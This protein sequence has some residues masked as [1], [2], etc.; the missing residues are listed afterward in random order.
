MSTTFSPADT[1]HLTNLTKVFFPEHGYTK[2]DLLDYYRAAAPFI[3]PYLADRPMVL[4]RHVDGH[5]KKEFFQRVSRRCPAWV[6]IARIE[7]DGGRKLRDFHLCQDWPTLLWLA[8]FGC[9]EF[10]PWASRVGSLDRPDYMVLDLDPGPSVQFSQ[11]V[12]VALA[13]RR[14]LD[15]LGTASCVKT[16]GKRGL[17]VYVPFGRRYSFQQAKLFAEIIA[18]L[19]HRKLPALTTL[20]PRTELRQGRIYLDTTRNSRGQAVAAPYSVRPHPGATVSTPLKWSEVRKGLDPAKF[21]SRRCSAWSKKWATSGSPSWR[22]AL[23]F[24]SASGD[25]N[26]C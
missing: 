23:S 2:R 19:V 9:I 4:H 15:K 26:M 25:S 5:D 24:A 14:V 8:N 17:H 22:T 21:N 11:T 13:V 10:I 1:L 20:D 12:E 16:S 7:P 18:H 6:K 3:L